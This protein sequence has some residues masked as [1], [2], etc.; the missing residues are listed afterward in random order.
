MALPF[1]SLFAEAP[2]GARPVFRLRSAAPLR[3]DATRATS[4]A[5]SSGST[6]GGRHRA[7]RVTPFD[8]LHPALR[9]HI[10]NTLGWNDLHPSQQDAIQPV[11]RGE[12]VL[13]LAPT[14]GGKTEAA[15]VPASRIASE[16]RRGLSVLD[17]CPLKA[18]LNNLEPRLSAMPPSW[19][20]APASGSD[21]GDA[22][23]RRML[24]DPPDI[25]RLPGGASRR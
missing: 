19:A 5:S 4:A 25:F 11:L 13:L 9:F 21:V 6:L 12:N 2:I 3:A 15:G 1:A 16:G 17:I 7:G 8:D 14:A 10:V 20:S 18:L 22:A 24:R 23:R